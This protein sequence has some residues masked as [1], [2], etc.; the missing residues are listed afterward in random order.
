MRAHE[1]AL[2]E[3]RK[4][5]IFSARAPFAAQAC[6]RIC[7]P[8]GML[9]A[10]RGRCMNFDDRAGPLSTLLPPTPSARAAK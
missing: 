3:K 7:T 6:R 1:C 2:D 5:P 9:S 10:R 4:R 8:A